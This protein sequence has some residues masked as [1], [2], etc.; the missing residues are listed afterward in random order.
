MS[1]Q[2][3]DEVE[4]FKSNLKESPQAF[5]KTARPPSLEGRFFLTDGLPSQNI[6]SF[7]PF[8]Q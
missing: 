1:T 5:L 7:F 2:L 3:L 6:Y 4:V 8:T